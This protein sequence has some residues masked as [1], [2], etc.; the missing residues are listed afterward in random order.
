M[1]TSIYNRTQNFLNK[2]KLIHNN[3]YDYSLVDYVN[4]Y[5]KVKI[6][7]PVHGIFE[8]EP[9]SHLNNI[10][11]KK[12]SN[13]NRVGFINNTILN[14]DPKLA[15]KDATLYLIKHENLYK[16]GISINIYKRFNKSVQVI[17]E[18]DNI[19]LLEAFT[20]EQEILEQYSQY[21]EKP[22]NWNYGGDTEFIN[23]S[24]DQRDEIIN[25][26]SAYGIAKGKVSC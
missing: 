12:C 21:R 24:N 8:Q 23:I 20:K 13:E 18:L 16:I 4:N 17:S 25:N 6:I 19:T 22:K 10:G 9:R 5:T 14:R 2:A 3:K 7:C 15:N 1:T 26:I 11:C